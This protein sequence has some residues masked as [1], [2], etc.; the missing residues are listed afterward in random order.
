MFFWDPLQFNIKETEKKQFI[1]QVSNC[2]F[3][4][5]SNIRED[6][7]KVKINFSIK[8]IL[9][10]NIESILVLPLILD[11][12]NSSQNLDSLSI[13]KVVPSSKFLGNWNGKSHNW[14][15][16]ELYLGLVI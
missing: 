1:R 5:V 8:L 3:F 7:T 15:V 16:S 14:Y 6:A 2:G 11:K 10:P 9:F 12:K 4:A 13:P